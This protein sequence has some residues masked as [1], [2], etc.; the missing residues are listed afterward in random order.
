MWAIGQTPGNVGRWDSN[1]T[2]SKMQEVLGKGKSSY[3][4]DFAALGV[5]DTYYVAYSGGAA[6]PRY[7]FDG[8]YRGLAKWLNDSKRPPIV[9]TTSFVTSRSNVCLPQA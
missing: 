6:K 1:S 9:R 3:V 7:N 5:D 4:L 8:N 2:Q